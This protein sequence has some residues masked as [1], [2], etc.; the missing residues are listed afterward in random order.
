MAIGLQFANITR[1]EWKEGK[2]PRGTWYPYPVG[3]EEMPGHERLRR[4]ERVIVYV[5]CPECGKVLEVSSAIHKTIDA[6]GR[7]M[8]SF[9]CKAP[10][11]WHVFIR[12]RGW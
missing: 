10:C 1:E 9:V 2:Q 11:R 6:D 7:V 5:C 3:P 8:P 4:G 12:L